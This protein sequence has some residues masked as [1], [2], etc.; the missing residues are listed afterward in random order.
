M[1]KYASGL[2]DLRILGLITVL[3]TYGLIVL[4]G[5]VRATDSGTACPDWPLCH[6]QV[7]PPAETKVLIEFS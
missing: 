7:I 5:V 6:G 4:G 3:A 2:L 1:K